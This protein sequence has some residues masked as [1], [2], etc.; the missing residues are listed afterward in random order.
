MAASGKERISKAEALSFLLTHIV[1]ERGF[2]LELDQLGLF[3]LN[4]V[5]QRAVDEISDTESI[6]PH[7]VIE[8][9]AAEYL[10]NK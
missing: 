10:D 5:A 9:L 6:I 7:E 1:V 2:A 8:R 4:S 3:K